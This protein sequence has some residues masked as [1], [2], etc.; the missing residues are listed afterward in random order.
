MKSDM[1]E[2]LGSL[3]VPADTPANRALGLNAFGDG[4]FVC[5]LDQI[6]Q[7]GLKAA[8]VG[9]VSTLGF[10]LLSEAAGTFEEYVFDSLTYFLRPQ[11]PT[12]TPGELI[13]GFSP[14]ST[15]DSPADEIQAG[16]AT[17][18]STQP[19][20]C[21]NSLSIPKEFLNGKRFVRTEVTPK[22]GEDIRLNDVGKLFI[23]AA[24]F[25]APAAGLTMKRHKVRTVSRFGVEKFVE[26]DGFDVGALDV[27]YH[28]HFL[29]TEQRTG[30]IQPFTHSSVTYF[31]LPPASLDLLT[32]KLG[33]AKARELCDTFPLKTK[34]WQISH[35][36]RLWNLTLTNTVE[37]FVADYADTLYSTG[38][39]CPNML[40]L[41]TGVLAATSDLE[42]RT[43][44]GLYD[45]TFSG[46]VTASTT[47]AVAGFDT[48]MVLTL[49]LQRFDEDST[50]WV[51]M[52]ASA[53]TPIGTGQAPIWSSTWYQNTSG[54]S[55]V[56]GFS[57]SGRMTTNTV[58]FSLSPEER[59]RIR[60]RQ[61]GTPV[62][63]SGQPVSSSGLAITE[64][65]LTLR[66]ILG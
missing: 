58:V 32:A 12:D 24:G 49:N 42:F 59:Y 29:G 10:P 56:T 18:V 1:T 39:G 62:F 22:L 23:S 53:G 65:S 27:E 17:V 3:I 26:V 40:E 55:G 25:D 9:A 44:S 45:M 48:M 2:R 16:D 31:E 50:S 61:F 33:E 28:C 41:D 46:Q 30:L 21:N 14:E 11:V 36:Q 38:G 34:E 6:I 13:M 8:T 52:T 19:I 35:W 66:A 37:V 4:G 5:I 54:G 20:W 7:P 51:N 57:F 47:S 64:G 15:T 63:G 43:P 60:F